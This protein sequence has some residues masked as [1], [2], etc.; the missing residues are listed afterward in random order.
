[1]KSHFSLFV[2]ALI[3]LL[4]PINSLYAQ[5]DSL[6]MN[7]GEI[8]AGEV[9]DLKQGVI[10]IETEYSDSDFNIE[11]DKVKYINTQRK[12]II[13]MSN[14]DRYNG[15]LRSNGN[16]DLVVIQDIDTGPSTVNL[17]DIVYLKSVEDNFLSRINLKYEFPL[18][19]FINLGFTLNYDNQPVEDASET[20]YVLQTTFGWEL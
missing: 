18:D 15:T 10:T 4:L 7:T 14:G 16:P 1:M 5:I 9:K 8:L 20:D 19:F 3:I 12:Y 13:T 11:W 2:I 17:I 6:I